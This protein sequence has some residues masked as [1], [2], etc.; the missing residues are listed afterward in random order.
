MPADARI[1]GRFQHTSHARMTGD[2]RPNYM[3]KPTGLT[4]PLNKR[5]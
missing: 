2:Y 4:S 1:Y 3:G 5:T